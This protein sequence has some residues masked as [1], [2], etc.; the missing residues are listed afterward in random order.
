MFIMLVGCPASG[1][2]TWAKNFK[3]WERYKD[4]VVIISSDAIREELWGDERIQRDPEKVFKLAHERIIN[5]LKVGTGCVIFDATNIKRKNRV[6]LMQ[7]IKKFNCTKRCVVFAEPY[8][9]LCERN[10]L[11]SRS[12]PKE[13]IWRMFTQF[14]TPLFT[15]GFNEIEVVNSNA[16]DMD[17]WI[18]SMRDFDQENPHHKLDLFEHC[19]A[20]AKYIYGNDKLA[21]DK[22]IV[23]K[24]AMLHDIGKL[25]TKTFTNMKGETTDVAHY[26]GHENVGAY[27]ALMYK[28][29]WCPEV[30][31]TISQL[32]CY[33]MIPYFIKTERAQHKWEE[34]LGDLYPLVTLLHEADEYAH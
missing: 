20:A 24:A 33:H 3:S 6:V 23:A 14:E 9:V 5:E 28:T 16:A 4:E 29:N 34:I 32:I 18:N 8:D 26:Y 22:S 7:K 25:S 30:R 31:L 12:V 19:Y 21:V 27:L 10:H 17:A 2:S 11:R 1:K 15:E 13:V